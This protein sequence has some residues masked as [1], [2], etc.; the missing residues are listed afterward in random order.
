MS[1]THDP[2]IAPAAF[3]TPPAVFDQAP[4][5]EDL[6]AVRITLEAVGGGDHVQWA[7]G[8]VAVSGSKQLVVTSDRGRGW[9]PPNAVLP[10]NIELPWRH[11]EAAQWEGLL[12]PARVIVEYAAAI[13]G[14]LTALAS[15][16]FS[17]P[18]VVADVPFAYV[19]ATER[20][21]PELLT[22]LILQGPTATRIE[23]QVD[24]K[25]RDKARAVTIEAEQRQL[26]LNCAYEAHID[27]EKLSGG[28]GHSDARQRLFDVL[29]NRQGVAPARI[30]EVRPLWDELE[31]ER[32]ALR[33]LEHAARVDVRDVAIGQLDNSGG[34]GLPYLVQGYATEAALG[35]LTASAAGAF[36]HALYYWAM[37]LKYLPTADADA[38][39]S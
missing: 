21:H 31:N 30:A 26:A 36:S 13:G 14:T 12:D 5:N 7:A 16:M 24:Q 27:A 17:P 11:P 10:A 3:V 2:L 25:W 33:D 34:D 4:G 38:V 32:I 39:A 28:V 18:G 15:T 35:L 8:M 37:L 22:S 19:D 20:A 23:L 9:M 29:R 6:A 1:G